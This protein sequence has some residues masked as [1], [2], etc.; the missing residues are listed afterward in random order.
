MADMAGPFKIIL[1]ELAGP[2]AAELGNPAA[3]RVQAELARLLDLDEGMA[4]SIVGAMPIVIVHGLSARQAGAARE[5]LQILV[6][7][8]CK[9]VT[10]DEAGDTL[11]HV[12]WPVVPQIAQVEEEQPAA[13]AGGA[14]SHAAPE[15][16]TLTC[17]SCFSTFR[18]S[19]TGAHA[20][21]HAQ[22]HAQPHSSGESR[23]ASR[24]RSLGAAAPPSR[25][26]AE[27]VF[28]S[29]EEEPEDDWMSPPVTRVP[30]PGR[31]TPAPEPSPEPSRPASGGTARFNEAALLAY[32][33][34]DE[35]PPPPP[36]PPPPAPLHMSFSDTQVDPFE[37][38]ST[39]SASGLGPLDVA[40]DESSFEATG[41]LHDSGSDILDLEPPH[42][43][44]ELERE[45]S[46]SRSGTAFEDDFDLLG[47]SDDGEHDPP[48]RRQHRRRPV[49]GRDRRH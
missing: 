40:G 25:A 41:S 7:L 2:A 36:A 22:T 16:G 31:H 37:L 44:A 35:P 3:D 14:P 45:R 43:E 8:G 18:L 12:N 30:A 17:P 32:A 48:D 11:P 20:H 6:Q 10:T 9:V 34:A 28:P 15:P 46:R 29:D 33:R 1:S 4:A 47:A 49:P 23:E 24:E 42:R 26:R 38:G 39:T 19:P 27:Q 13:G 21:S 5:R